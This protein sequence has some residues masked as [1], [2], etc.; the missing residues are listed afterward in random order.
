MKRIV[1]LICL[2]VVA[3]SMMAT[4]ARRE[5]RIRVDANGVEKIVYPHGDED[6]HYL[7]DEAGNWLDENTLLPLTEETKRAKLN[8]K[9]RRSVRRAMKETGLD[10]LLAPRG[11][12]ILVSFLDT[13]FTHTNEAVVDWAMGENYTYNGATGSINRYF[14]DVSL[15]QYDLH[16][17]VF[18]PVQVSKTATYYGKNLSNGDDQ[19][20][21]ELI[22]EACQLAA[23]QGADF[24][25]YDSDNDGK[26]DFVVI[27]Y[28]GYGEADNYPDMPNTIW[29]HQYDLSMTG[30]DFTLNGKTIDHYCCL[31]EIDGATHDLSGIGT[32][33]HEFSHVM[34]L[35]DIYATIQGTHKTLGKWDIMDYGCYC[36]D[37]N[38]PPSYSAYEQWWMGWIE[39]THLNQAAS[40]T[41]NTLYPDGTAAYITESGEPV[42]NILRP[43][44]T[45]FYVL[46]NRQQTGWDTYLPGHGMLITKINFHY[47][48]WRNNTVNNSATTMGID[49][50]EA[51]GLTP[52]QGKTGYL[53]KQ[54]DAFPADSVTSFTAVSTYQIT[55][56]AEKDGI[57]SFD[58]NGGGDSTHL[59]MQESYPV[60]KA[61]KILRNGQVVI[62]RGGRLYD[63]LGRQL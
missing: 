53:G 39:P 46:E 57:I 14:K 20:A 34:G 24:S 61:Y 25:Q 58:V 47:N 38:T 44:P 6:F 1:S 28:A 41:L 32:F 48:W 59:D 26:V 16:L 52:S 49:L 51:D 40:V 35:P 17:D 8:T 22:V 29:P 45:V 60:E 19:H 21:D 63:I 37:G 55:N 10:R 30:K 50:M 33:C 11:P 23:E 7:T 18:G 5:G 13:I 15:G 43:N 27:I 56:I 4:P 36:N 62:K 3:L 54:G 2:C 31:N 9:T 12:V 42:T